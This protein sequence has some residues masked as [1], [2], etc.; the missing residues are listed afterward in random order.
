MFENPSTLEDLCLETVCDN[1]TTYARSNTD[2]RNDWWNKCM[3]GSTD[4]ETRYQF[5]DPDIFLITEISEKLLQKL[6]EKGLLDDSLLHIFTEQNTKLRKFRINNCMVTKRGLRILKQHKVSEIECTNLK[7]TSIGDIIDCLSDWSMENLYYANFSDCTFIDELRY[8]FMVKIA[9]LKNLKHLNLSYTELN[10]STFKIIC[11]DLKQLEKLDISGTNVFDL[12]PLAKLEEK[13]TSLS[14]CD[15]PHLD[16]ISLTIK[17]LHHLRYLDVSFFNEKDM[18]HIENHTQLLETLQ[19]PHMLPELR[20]LDLSGW[21]EHVSKLVLLKILESHPKL[22]FLGLVLCYVSQDPAFTR[23][24]EIAANL[25]VAGVGNEAQIKVTLKRYR[26]RFNYV[27]K[28]LYHLFQMTSSFHEARPDILRLV[29][30]VM[31]SHLNKFGVQMAATAC[32]YNLTRGELSKNI[33]PHTLSRAVDLTLAVMNMYPEEFQLQKNALLMLCS[34]RILQDVSFDRFKCA[35]LVLD[36]LCH[37]DDVNMDRMAVAICSILAAKISTEETSELGARHE[38]MLK[39]LA[40]VRTRVVSCSADITLKF[41]L[42][43]LWNLTDESAA[44]CTVFLEQQGVHLFLSVLRVFKDNSAIETKVLGLLNN[45]AEVARLREHLMQTDLMKELFVL[46]KSEN[47]DVSYFAAGIVAHL[48]SDCE[49]L[50]KTLGYSRDDM[51]RELESA[52]IQWKVPESEMVAYRSFRPFFP[53]LRVEMDYRVQLWAVWAIHHVC[54]KNPKRYCQMLREETGHVLLTDLLNFDG[55]H[56][57]IKSI[58]LLII[59]TLEANA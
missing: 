30:P 53:L 35:R 13:L 51:L 45:I 23:P 10:Q 48:A 52:V 12:S 39:L 28:A 31:E 57:E 3:D 58:C 7:R 43:A 19:N 49:E 24:G 2:T 59:N 54:T 11:E 1:I 36:A 6:S 29:L 33:H 5:K 42:S 4:D 26:D 38:Y 27:Q 18:A 21:R 17:Q 56:P 34:D 20:Y 47:I 44:T 32:L 15:L 40:M 16:N 14:I 37:F 46:L 41:T 55:S 9:N 50:W 22:E 25:V 8:S